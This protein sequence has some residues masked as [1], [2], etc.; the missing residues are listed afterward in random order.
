MMPGK[1]I[2]FI[3]VFT[4]ISCVVPVKA[5]DIFV[6]IPPQEMLLNAI[7]GDWNTI[8]VLVGPGDNMH[9]FEP[10][11]RQ[12]MTLGRSQLYF[13]MELPFE[14]FIRKKLASVTDTLEIVD[15]TVGIGRRVM[16]ESRAQ[17]NRAA[18]SSAGPDPHVWMNPQNL[19]IMAQNMAA[20]LVRID[21]EHAG[22]YLKNRDALITRISKTDS[23]LEKI[24]TPLK[25][26]RFYVYHPAFGYFGDRYGLTQTAVETG[27]K[28]PSPRQLSGLI[29]RAQKDGIRIILVQAQFDQRAA[30]VIADGIGG[31]VA[32]VNPMARDILSELE[33]LAETMRTADGKPVK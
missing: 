18:E 3:V 29:S 32:E 28:S 25:G 5:L 9:T 21:P 20:A 2:Q 15:C 23:K 7:S 26:Q 10:S 24:L 6:S 4:L 12:V 14:T 30:Q 17:S 19:I 16:T 1:I 11:P 22:E 33:S 27:G 13:V 31:T 8:H